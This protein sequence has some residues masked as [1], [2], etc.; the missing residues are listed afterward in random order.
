MSEIKAPEAQYIIDCIDN[1]AMGHED[2]AGLMAH[3]AVA[4]KELASIKEF[5]EA[6]NARIAELEQALADEKADHGVTREAL[7][8][9]VGLLPEGGG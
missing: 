8:D 6:K 1:M 4:K 2:D 3:A 9:L 7:C 5:I